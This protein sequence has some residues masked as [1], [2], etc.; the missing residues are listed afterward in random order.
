MKARYSRH[1][2]RPVST[3]LDHERVRELALHLRDVG[4]E[5]DLGEAGLRRA[6]VAAPLL[7]LAPEDL[8]KDE[9][10][11]LVHLVEP[12]RDADPGIFVI[13]TVFEKEPWEK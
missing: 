11:N 2:A 4:D 12:G 3:G 8:V 13:Q 9:H 10:G 7:V 6:E 5:E 1:P